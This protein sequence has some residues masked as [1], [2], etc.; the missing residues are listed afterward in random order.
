MLN[1]QF[2]EQEQEVILSGVYWKIIYPQMISLWALM[3]CD[4]VFKQPVLTPK[5]ADANAALCF[6][7]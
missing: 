5:E 3:S 2:E 7:A 4:N 1:I 6:L